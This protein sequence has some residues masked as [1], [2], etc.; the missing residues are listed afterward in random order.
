MG[1]LLIY[2]DRSERLNTIYYYFNIFLKSKSIRDL[3]TFYIWAFLTF[4]FF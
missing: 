3:V 4:Q 1:I 2:I